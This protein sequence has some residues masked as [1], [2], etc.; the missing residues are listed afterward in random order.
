[1]EDLKYLFSNPYVWLFI[2]FSFSLPYIL[3]YIRRFYPEKLQQQMAKEEVCILEKSKKPEMKHLQKI[4]QIG[5]LFSFFVTL[6]VAYY[7]QS[8]EVTKTVFI[9]LVSL[10]AI[11]VTV[12]EYKIKKD[13]TCSHISVKYYIVM[14]V[15]ICIITFVL[16]TVFKK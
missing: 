7:Y 8:L 2:I 10:I 13:K 1:M 3:K 9:S 12:S 14:F 6:L 5:T 15:I 4:F 11:Y 16:A